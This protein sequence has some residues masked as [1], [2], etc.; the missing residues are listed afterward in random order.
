M[1]PAPGEMP[2][3]I[4]AGQPPLGIDAESVVE[5][6]VPGLKVAKVYRGGAAEKAGLHEGDVIRSVNGY[7]TKQPSDLA[8]IA[9]KR[10]PD[11]VL[12][13]SVLPRARVR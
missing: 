9:A 12:R 1:T 11:K 3:G 10:S 13:M 7:V 8:W 6:G 5:A 2:D 4:G